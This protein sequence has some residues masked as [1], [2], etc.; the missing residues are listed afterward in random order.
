MFIQFEVLPYITKVLSH[1]AAYTIRRETGNNHN[2]RQ[3]P[4][5]LKEGFKFAF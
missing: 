1:F 2:E 3:K 5:F 4:D